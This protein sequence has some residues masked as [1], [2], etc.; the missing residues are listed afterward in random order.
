MSRRDELSVCT[1]DRPRHP[2]IEKQVIPRNLFLRNPGSLRDQLRKCSFCR[3]I[4]QH[5]KHICLDIVMHAVVGFTVHMN[6]DIRDHDQIAVDVHKLRPEMISFLNYYA[7]CDGQRTVKPRRD[8]HTAVSLH[9]QTNISSGCL[10]FRICLDSKC[11][12]VAVRGRDHVPGKIRNLPSVFPFGNPERDHRR[13]VSGY[14][15]LSAGLQAPAFLLEALP[16]S[17]LLQNLPDAVDSVECC[18]T[19]INKRQQLPGYFFI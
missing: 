5:R 14:K 13:I 3:L 9:I 1:P 17:V 11:R 12:A 16:V 15:I 2:G 7:S 4:S 8:Q 19:L 10:H 18:R 6:G